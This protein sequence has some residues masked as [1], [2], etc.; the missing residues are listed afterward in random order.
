MDFPTLEDLKDLHSFYVKFATSYLEEDISTFVSYKETE[1]SGYDD[2]GNFIGYESINN[3]DAEGLINLF[4]NKRKVKIIDH[5]INIFEIM[6]KKI[7]ELEEYELCS[8]LKRRLEI[9]RYVKKN[10]I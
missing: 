1:L 5:S 3:I 4:V 2:D 7:E 9:I 6:L 10:N 8:R